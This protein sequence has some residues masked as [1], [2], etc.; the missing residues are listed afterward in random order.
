MTMLRQEI[1]SVVDEGESSNYHM[2]YIR[3]YTPSS[4]RTRAP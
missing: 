2:S 4:S 3:A 1:Q